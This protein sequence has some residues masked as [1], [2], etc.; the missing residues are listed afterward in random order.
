MRAA[1]IIPTYNESQNIE[2]LVESISNLGLDIKILIV[3]DN[4]P[5]GTGKIA[6]KLAS[7]YSHVHVIHR[8]RKKGRGSACIAGFK[9]ALNLDLDYILEMDADFSHDPKAIP[10]FLKKMSGAQ[11]IIGSRYLKGSQIIDWGPYRPI[12]SR[13]ANLYARFLL[14]IP[15][16]DYTNGYR[17][18]SRESLSNIDFNQINT[19][20]YIVLSEMAYQLYQKG[21]RFSEIPITFVNRRRGL[22][23]FT[24]KEI[25][26]AFVG[27]LCLRLRRFYFWRR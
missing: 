18:Y 6:D 20:G 12:F 3:D 26:S 8:E 24:L 9:Y 23:N 10:E 16:T 11:V 25:V 19:T 2:A 22:S 27:V 4:S 1:V 14:R 13:L 15:I 17:C 21:V 7:K 5:D